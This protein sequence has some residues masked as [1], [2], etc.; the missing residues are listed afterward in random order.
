MAR[1][2]RVFLTH[3]NTP[4]E[5]VIAGDPGQCKALIAELDAKS[6]RAPANHVMHCSIVDGERAGLADLNHYPTGD[7][8][9]LELFSSY[10]YGPVTDIDSDV[11]ADHIAETLR[12]TVDFPRLVRTAYQRGYRY[13]IEVGPASTCARW[14]RETLGADP[15]LSVSIDRRGAKVAVNIARVV[16]RLV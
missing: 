2:D 10:D 1:Y 15:H 4:N 3:V 13:F 7:T 5:V 14:V 11:L 12:S 8:R 6:A 16:A 9:G